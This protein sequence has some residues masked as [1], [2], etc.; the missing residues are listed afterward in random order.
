MC[1]MLKYKNYLISSQPF[2]QILKKHGKSKL[3]PVIW[4]VHNNDHFQIFIDKRT[5]NYD[6]YDDEITVYFPLLKV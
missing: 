2:F 4:Y 1:K 5:G 3:D 6:D